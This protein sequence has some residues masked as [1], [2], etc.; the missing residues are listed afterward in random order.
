[1][2]VLAY[3]CLWSPVC[4]HLLLVFVFMYSNLYL[5]C[6]EM[7]ISSTRQL[8]TNS[9]NTCCSLHT[10]CMITVMQL[11]WKRLQKHF[12]V[13]VCVMGPNVFFFCI[14]LAAVRVF[15]WF[16]CKRRAILYTLSVIYANSLLAYLLS[17]LNI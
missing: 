1:M 17:L 10:T 13:G 12:S 3:V 11:I 14:Y 15:K 5:I 2:Y 8:V 4:S 6:K 16:T 9:D 7:L